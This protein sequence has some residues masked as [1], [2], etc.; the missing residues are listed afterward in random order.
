[1]KPEEKISKIEFDLEI[2][3]QMQRLLLHIDLSPD[4]K[5]EKLD[6][7]FSPDQSQTYPG[8]N[9]LESSKTRNVR[10]TKKVDQAELAKISAAAGVISSVNT[11]L[12]GSAEVASLGLGF[13]SLDSSGNLMKLS[14][15]QKVYC[16]YRLIG[17]NYGAYLKSYFQWSASKFDPETSRSESEMVSNNR[18][19][20]QNMLE[21]KV[22]LDPFEYGF[23]RLIFYS[24]SWALK[25]LA[26]LILRSSVY[27][28]RVKKWQAYFIGIS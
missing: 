27:S 2:K 13:L 24:V 3:S 1:M 7:I 22:P 11:Y 15:M 20:Y 5:E 6:L 10:V 9:L 4:L 14:Q 21:Y 25:I 12:G 28:G 8:F 18:K 16:R 23:L 17:M 19:Y 26:F